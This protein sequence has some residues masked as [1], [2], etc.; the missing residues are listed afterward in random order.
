MFDD[1][2][3][4]F[5]QNLDKLHEFIINIDTYRSK[6]DE[7][8]PIQLICCGTDWNENF[9]SIAVNASLDMVILIDSSFAALRYGNVDFQFHD[10]PNEDGKCDAILREFLSY[11][12]HMEAIFSFMYWISGSLKLY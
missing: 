4:L 5:N 2:Q 8:V 11:V 3:I 10:L 6:L 9:A 1:I 7:P 12:H